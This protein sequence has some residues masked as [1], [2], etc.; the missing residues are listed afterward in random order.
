MSTASKKPAGVDKPRK[1]MIQKYA[2]GN[3]DMLRFLSRMS[4]RY[5]INNFQVVL[6]P[7]SHKK[8]KLLAVI[9]FVLKKRFHI[10]DFRIWL[11][12]E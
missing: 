1:A 10:F 6:S 7:L 2:T 9:E 5:P 12:F 8:S 3:V 11:A 4:Q